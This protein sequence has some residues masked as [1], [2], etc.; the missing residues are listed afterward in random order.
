MRLAFRAGQVAAL[1]QFAQQEVG[2]RH[3]LGDLAVELFLAEFADVAV[4]VMFLRQEDE[5]EALVVG[6]GFQRIFQGA[7]GGLAAGVVAVEAEDDAVD[8]A[9]QFGHMGRGGG[10]AQC[11]HRVADPVLGQAMTSM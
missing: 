1:G 9:Q 5:G 6:Q 10:R 8:L 7:P 4:R 11:R 2:Q 3:G